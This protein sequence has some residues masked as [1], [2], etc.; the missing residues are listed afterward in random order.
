[1]LKNIELRNRF[2]FAAAASGGAADSAGVITSDKIE[3][4]VTYAQCGVGLIITGAVGILDGLEGISGWSR[5]KI[6]K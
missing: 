6:A 3:R 5:L 4:L 2:V 1:L